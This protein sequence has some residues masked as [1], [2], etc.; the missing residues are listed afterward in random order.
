MCAHWSVRDLLTGMGVLQAFHEQD[1]L[2]A[3]AEAAEKAA[4]EKVLAHELTSCVL[5]LTV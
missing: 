4:A 5:W 1:P 2:E 3:A